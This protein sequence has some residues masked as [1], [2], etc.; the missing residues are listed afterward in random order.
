M[1][2]SGRSHLQLRTGQEGKQQWLPEGTLPSLNSLTFLQSPKTAVYNLFGGFQNLM[3]AMASLQENTV[4]IHFCTQLPKRLQNVQ[5]H[6]WTLQNCA[7]HH[8]SC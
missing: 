5:A 6:P 2:S 3:E 7:V 1:L 4:D 8:G